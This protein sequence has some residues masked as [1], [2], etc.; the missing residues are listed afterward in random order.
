[1]TNRLSAFR[2]PWWLR[3]PH[4]QTIAASHLWPRPKIAYERERLELDDGDFVDL[5]WGRDFA[6]RPTVLILHGLEGSSQSPYALRLV[7][8]LQ[9]ARINSVVMNFRGRSGE[10]NRLN[11]AYTAGDTGDLKQVVAHLRSRLAPTKPELFA[12]GYSLGGNLL[13]K[14]LGESQTRDIQA[15]VAVSVPYRLD[16]AA[17]RMEQGFSRLYQQVLL[18]QLRATTQRRAARFPQ[19]VGAEELARL[20]TF[21]AF[22]DRVTAPLHGYS[23]VEEYYATASSRQYLKSIATP[24]LLLHALDDPFM[25]AQTVPTVEELSPLVQ[26]ECSEH[27]GHVGFVSHKKNQRFWL[28]GRIL[29]WLDEQG[30]GESG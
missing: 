1:M 29:Q 27:G 8:A 23:G 21:R 20:K 10:P 26:L 9:E 5:D 24:T 25:F 28:Q 14:Y 30:P 18:R 15:A 4:L 16:D 11:R 2:P 6:H 3:N 22:D 7:E 13:L 17:E 12:V 19:P